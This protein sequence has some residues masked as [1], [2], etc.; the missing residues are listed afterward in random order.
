M[1]RTNIRDLLVLHFDDSGRQIGFDKVQILTRVHTDHMNVD[2]LTIHLLQTPFQCAGVNRHRPLGQRRK[3][4]V[5]FLPVLHQWPHGV[6]VH[7]TVHVHR[8]HALAANQHLSRA[9]GA[10]SDANALAA[11]R[12]H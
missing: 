1:G 8:A 3:P 6:H 9:A 7:M 11:L 12:P 10:W 5:H 2:A 4:L